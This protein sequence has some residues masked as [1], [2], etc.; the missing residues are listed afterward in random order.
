V[1]IRKFLAFISALSCA[2][3]PLGC[4]ARRNQP[5]SAGSPELAQKIYLP[6]VS[7]FG[8][9]NDYLYHGAQPK[10]DGLEQ[11]KSF[12]IDTIVDL[13]GE[14]RGLV[15]NE[16]HRAE[17]L[18]MRF[19]NIP[20]SGW[21]APKD[22]E[23][24]QFFALILERPRRTIFIHCWLGRDR[25]STFIAAYR[26]AFQHW[27]PQQAIEEM[28]AFHYLEFWH[29]NMRQWVEHF[30]ERLA[31]SPQLAP[32]RHIDEAQALQIQPVPEH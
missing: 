20:G 29:G 3:V 7:D 18:G 1:S 32:F 28:R 9:V 26:I 15:E 30:P 17:S 23:I 31:Q 22:A 16:R 21:A 25:S 10:S 13:R 27:T 8:K 14:L 5:Q 24:A 6:G 19:V 2:A 12:H 11:L 4:S